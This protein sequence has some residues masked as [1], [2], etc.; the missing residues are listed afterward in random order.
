MAKSL[1]DSELDESSISLNALKIILECPVCLTL[2]NTTPIFRCDNGHL[3]CKD[4]RVKVE[5]CPECRILLGYSRCLTSERIVS[6]A[7]SHTLPCRFADRGC[8]GKFNREKLKVHEVECTNS[9]VKCSMTVETCNENIPLLKVW[10]HMKS[11][12]WERFKTCFGGHLHGILTNANVKNE[13][14]SK[15]I[16]FSLDPIHS[17]YAEHHFFTKICRKENSWHF[18][19]YILGLDKEAQK[20]DAKILLRSKKNTNSNIEIQ[21]LEASSYIR[22]RNSAANQEIQFKG[23]CV[24]SL[25]NSSMNIIDE[26][27]KLPHLVVTQATM[28]SFFDLING[29]GELEYKFSILKSK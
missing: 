2:F 26:K 10:E 11:K 14:R 29:E 13:P 23:K 24:S 18:W 28:N 25:L 16:S 21:G 8:K 9:L 7:M 15:F 20:F 22:E 17:L 27:T 4:C 3:V 6:S 12:H 5:K 1:N 19:V